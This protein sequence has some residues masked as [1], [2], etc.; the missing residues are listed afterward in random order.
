MGKHDVITKPEVHNV[1]PCRQRKI[2]PRAQVT[3]TEDF[4]KFVTLSL[5]YVIGQT[6]RHTDTHIAILRTITGGEVI[7]FRLHTGISKI[8]HIE[9]GTVSL[10]RTFSRSAP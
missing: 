8:S 10:P 6:D 3:C 7:S 9:I 5:R 2:E 1:F 4:V